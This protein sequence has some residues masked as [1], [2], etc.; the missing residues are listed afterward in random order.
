VGTDSSELCNHSCVSRPSPHP[1]LHRHSGLSLCGNLSETPAHGR[2]TGFRIADGNHCQHGPML[3][4]FTCS[5]GVPLSRPAVGQRPTISPL[6]SS[7]HNQDHSINLTKP[8][9]VINLP[10]RHE[11]NQTRWLLLHASSP[12][13]KVAVCSTVT[14]SVVHE[15]GSRT[16][17]ASESVRA[18]TKAQAALQ[19]RP[20][21]CR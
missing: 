13:T 9:P 15:S 18:Q 7:R 8:S 2:Q 19:P 3:L 6:Q 5:G 16:P 1:S 12:G 4:T 20:R 11:S 10:G 17:V 14:L 21:G